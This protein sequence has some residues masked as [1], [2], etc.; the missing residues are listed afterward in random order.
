VKPGRLYW[1]KYAGN[2]IGENLALTYRLQRSLL[3]LSRRDHVRVTV[4]GVWPGSPKQILSFENPC[5]YENELQSAAIKAATKD[6]TGKLNLLFVG[7]LTNAKGILELVEAVLSEKLNDRFEHIYIAGDGDLHD[8]ISKLVSR[9]GKCKIHVLGHQSRD[10]IN[11]LYELCHV[12]ILPSLSEGFPKV[13]AEGAAYGCIPIVT[14]VSSVSQYVLE[15]Q[16]GYL[17]SDNTPKRILTVLNSLAANV[18]LKEFSI[19][20][21]KMATNFTYER[22]VSRIKKEVFDLESHD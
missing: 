12:V 16:N 21:Q 8:S 10:A 2:W 20:A 5:I 9:Q 15:G 17:L 13:I 6:F 22:F 18:S 3:K 1:H 19:E 11:K 14:D 4:N 7:N